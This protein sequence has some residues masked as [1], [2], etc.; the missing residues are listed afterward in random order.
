[1]HAGLVGD[2]V[3]PV[4][5][6]RDHAE[7]GCG[8]R[9]VRFFVEGLRLATTPWGQ[10]KQQPFLGPHVFVES[11]RRRLPAGS[12]RHEVPQA[13]A[14]PVQQH[15]AD[16]ARQCDDRNTATAGADASGGYTLKEIVDYFGLHY[17]RVSKIVRLAKGATEEK[18]ERPDPAILPTWPGRRST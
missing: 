15:L 12:D 13:R 18:R 3:L 7:S 1:M 10:V 8:V 6:R 14:R 9:Y 4:R 16:F 5:I 2:A 17:S 11:V